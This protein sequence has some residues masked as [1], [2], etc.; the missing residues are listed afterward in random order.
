MVLNKE[1]FIHVRIFFFC[2]IT[3][4]KSY[5]AIIEIEHR[6]ITNLFF[7]VQKKKSQTQVTT[8]QTPSSIPLFH[9]L[10][11]ASNKKFAWFLLGNGDSRLYKYFK[12]H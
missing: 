4:V 5:K 2:H 6:E 8:Q 10:T 9:T 12:G 11:I 1:P 3:G 7:Q